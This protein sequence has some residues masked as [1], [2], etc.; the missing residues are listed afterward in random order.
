MPIFVGLHWSDTSKVLPLIEQP[1][2]QVEAT[3]MKRIDENNDGKLSWEELEKYFKEQALFPQWRAFRALQK[4]DDNN[5]GYIS[6]NEIKKFSDYLR[7]RKFNDGVLSKE[8][9]AKVFQELGSRFPG[10][11]AHRALR[12]ADANNDGYISLD[13]KN[14][15]MAYINERKYKINEHV[16]YTEAELKDVIRGC[17]RDGDGHLSRKDLEKAC[18]VLGSAALARRAFRALQHADE[19]GD[20]YIYLDHNHQLE[21]LVK[22]ALKQAYS[23]N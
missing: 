1:V 12:R 11:R 6:G 3:L 14:E 7:K 19:N 23:V 2:A 16:P 8:E 17:D 4:A 18:S 9:V 15:L 10:W 21:K 20:G 13:E 5:D 22:Y